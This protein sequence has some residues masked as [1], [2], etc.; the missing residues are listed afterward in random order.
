LKIAPEV[1]ETFES[2]T[3]GS[4]P[5]NWEI[6]DSVGGLANYDA[7]WRIRRSSELNKNVVT[8]TRT[9]DDTPGTYLSHLAYVGTTPRIKRG[10][11]PREAHYYV[12]TLIHMQNDVAHWANEHTL[13]GIV[14]EKYNL[15]VLAWS[16]DDGKN[17]GLRLYANGAGGKIADWDGETGITANTGQTGWN[18]WARLGM[19]IDLRKSLVT[20]YFNGKPVIGPMVVR[21]I[22]K[23]SA[24]YPIRTDVRATNNLL[25]FTDFRIYLLDGGK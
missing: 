3:I 24:G 6:V 23:N 10:G 18:W 25:E 9:K 15:E 21:S 4:A 22:R 1:H 2:E 11:I 19:D 7:D 17:W 16:K 20:V 8:A 12:E 5:M 13:Q 14:N